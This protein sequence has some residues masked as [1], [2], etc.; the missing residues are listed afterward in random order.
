MLELPLRTGSEELTEVMYYKTLLFALCLIAL[1]A[2]SSELAIG[3]DLG[4]TL[5]C[6]GLYKSVDGVPTGGL[7]ENEAGARLTPSVVSF[8]SGLKGGLSTL[9]IGKGAND[10]RTIAPA[11]TFFSIKRMIGRRYDDVKEML[12]D[13]PFVTA[14]CTRQMGND[15]AATA[16]IGTMIKNAS[17]ANDESISSVLSD[18][19]PTFEG[20]VCINLND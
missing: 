15:A 17:R 20:Q 19:L 10:R 4:T 7:V 16:S 1:Q 8:S 18:H 6:V 3:I 13:F 5:S 9:L 14:N 2:K 11:E 12:V